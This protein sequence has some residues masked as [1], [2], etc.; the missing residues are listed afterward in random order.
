MKDKTKEILKNT[1]HGILLCVLGFGSAIFVILTDYFV[2]EFPLA[3]LAALLILSSLLIIW[4]SIEI[5][6]AR[7]LMI[8]KKEFEKEDK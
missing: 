7:I 1:Y 4:G 8:L 6:L 3:I 2:A 5:S